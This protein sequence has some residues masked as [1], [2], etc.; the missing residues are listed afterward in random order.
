MTNGNNN[1][2]ILDFHGGPVVQ[3]LLPLQ[4][5]WVQSLV[6][7]LR[8]G[9]PHGVEKFINKKKNNGVIQVQVYK[10]GVNRTLRIWS[11]TPLCTTSNLNLL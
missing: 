10:N 9:M 7:E 1:G 5:A 6:R 8:S 11:Q 2:V 3:T 4:G